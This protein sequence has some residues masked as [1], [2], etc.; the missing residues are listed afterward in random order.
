MGS[1]SVLP[2]AHGLLPVA[3]RRNDK[4]RRGVEAV[5]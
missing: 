5:Q 4:A 1:A 2:V 3:K